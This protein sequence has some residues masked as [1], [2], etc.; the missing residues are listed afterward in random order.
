MST[1]PRAPNAS[2]P[3]SPTARAW[4][5]VSASALRSNFRRVRSLLGPGPEII[6]MVKADAYGLGMARAVEALSEEHPDGWG[7][8]TLD[9]AL[10]LKALGRAEPIQIYSPLPPED[11]KPALEAGLIVSLS[12]PQALLDQLASGHL[13]PATPGTFDVE[14]DTGMGRAGADPE[15]VEVW[16]AALLEGLKGTALHWRGVFTHLHSADHDDPARGDAAV[17]AQAERF[18]QTLAALDP[19]MAAA[20]HPRLR[21]HLANSAGLLRYPHLAASFDAVRPGITL[22]GGTT[23]VDE[24]LKDVV[25]VRARVIR[26]TEVE[27]GATLGY[28][29]T[30]VATAPER[31]VTLGIGYGDG[32][33]RSLSSRGEV[34]LRGRRVPILGRISMD[35]TVVLGTAVPDLEPGE[36]ATV[37]GWD[38]EARISPE[39]V[40]ALAGTIHYEILTGLGPRLPRVWTE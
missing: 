37:L 27:P 17:H 8:A 3:R 34:L 20:G 22:Y 25:A 23:G 5:E 13:T 2:H 28:G 21:R 33:P 12:D 9:E 38:G 15:K 6:P 19:L 40:A 36:V 16:A 1:E 18:R 32:L 26:V 4:V 24:G 30:H 10:E 29:A 11:L 39:E 14:I 7:V 35:M 31:W